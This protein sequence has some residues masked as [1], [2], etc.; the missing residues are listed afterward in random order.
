MAA[1]FSNFGSLKSTEV[2]ANNYS[3]PRDFGNFGSL[4]GGGG[5]G[6]QFHLELHDAISAIS[7]R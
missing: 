4:G 3:P 5:F 7:A 1:D 2:E 6:M